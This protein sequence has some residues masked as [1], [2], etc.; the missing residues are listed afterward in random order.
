MADLTKRLNGYRMVQTQRGDTAQAVALRELGDASRWP[1]VVSINALVPP[2]IS[3]D[4][5]STGVLKSGDLIRIPAA[6]TVV[7]SSAD[8]AQVYG[9]DA[10]LSN[11][12]L[13]SDGGDFVLAS[14]VDNLTQALRH[15]LDTDA[16]ELAFHPSYGSNIRRVVGMVAGPNASALAAAYGKAT[17]S[18]DARIEQVRSATASV[19]GDQI[20]VTIEAEAVSGKTVTVTQEM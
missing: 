12:L 16:G 18:A 1:E 3:D 6:Q 11:G 20:S 15:A 4:V 19:V 5:R 9:V 17:I 14:G 7:S 2:Y 10:K 8:P 13:A